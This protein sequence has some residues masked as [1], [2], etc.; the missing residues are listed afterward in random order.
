MKTDSTRT[1]V[2]PV[3]NL[4]NCWN[5]TNISINRTILK[6]QDVAN[7][8]KNWSFLNYSDVDDATNSAGT[9]ETTSI[10]PPTFTDAY[11]VETIVLSAIFLISFIGNTATLIQMYRMRKRR[12]TINTLIV[13][14]AIADLIVAFFCMAAEAFWNITI[15]FLAGN[16]MCKILRYIQVFA[17][18]LSTYITVVISLDRCCVILDPI[19]RNKAPQRVR[20]M[21]IVSWFLS[22]L[23]SIPQVMQIIFILHV[24]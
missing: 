20:M 19:S 8:H 15:Q 14:L 1:T 9:I 7:R 3:R 10:S 24:Y 4:D 22:A 11:M 6:F 2:I 13:N 23:F 16:A 21:I 5:E 12:S 18:L 17:F